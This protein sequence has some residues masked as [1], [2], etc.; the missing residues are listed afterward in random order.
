MSGIFI[1][2]RAFWKEE[3]N[4][5]SLTK[6]GIIFV[7]ILIV[8]FC[9][10]YKS[11]IETNI[12]LSDIKSTIKKH[13]TKKENGIKT[14][15]NNLKLKINPILQSSLDE[16]CY[17]NFRF[18]KLIRELL[19]LRCDKHNEDIS[20][21]IEHYYNYFFN[22]KKSKFEITSD[23]NIKENPNLT[24]HDG[25][26]CLNSGRGQIALKTENIPE[27]IEI[28]NMNIA[29]LYYNKGNPNLHIN[30]HM[31]RYTNKIKIHLFPAFQKI[32]YRKH[33]DRYYNGEQMYTKN[34]VIYSKEKDNFIRICNFK[35]DFIKYYENTIWIEFIWDAEIQNNLCFEDFWYFHNN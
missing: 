6:Y 34:L 1:K 31:V 28:K 33:I 29:N 3:Q 2:R 23:Y 12:K 18:N 17:F 24:I 25:K 26:I 9:F 15:S 27:C 20:K 14:I 8:F 7:F 4:E 5:T 16:E 13:I 10:I 35:D 32:L 22:R 21:S 11:E 30:L 19:F